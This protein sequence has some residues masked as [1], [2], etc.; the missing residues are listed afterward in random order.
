MSSQ[1]GVDPGVQQINT[2]CLKRQ[3]E[4]RV[5][6]L[7][8]ELV[9]HR[10]V[11]ACWSWAGSSPA[12]LRSLWH[13]CKETSCKTVTFL[14]LKRSVH[15]N[16][17]S[18][19]TCALTI[20]SEWSA[21][22]P[23]RCWAHTQHR[24]PRGPCQC[25]RCWRT[26][27]CDTG[28]PDRPFEPIYW[29]SSSRREDTNKQN[30]LF[31]LTNLLSKEDDMTEGHNCRDRDQSWWKNSKDFLIILSQYSHKKT[32]LT[33]LKSWFTPHLP[34]LHQRSG[35]SFQSVCLPPSGGWCQGETIQQP[36]LRWRYEP[37]AS[38]RHARGAAK[39]VSIRS[40]N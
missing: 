2:S 33:S 7:P 15:G 3:Q 26:G 27:S 9:Y 12:P 31:I 20:P 13:S 24:A 6:G 14:L 17:T 30:Q 1:M 4:P 8:V 23:W 36:L 10:G 19:C 40:I 37:K 29:T 5:L 21:S 32:L 11:T 39:K 35:P 16:W 34:H 18:A 28:F 22:C 38:C 25:S